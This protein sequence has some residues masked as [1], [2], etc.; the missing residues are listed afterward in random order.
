VEEKWREELE[1]L[2]GRP[3]TLDDLDRLPFTAMVFQE[4]LRLYPPALAFARRT[5]EEV[6][7]AGYTI[8]K[9]R[10]VFVSPYITQRNPKYFDSPEEFQPLRWKDYSG[11]KFAY[12][13]FGGGAKMCIGEPF[14]K[15]EGVIALATLGRRWKLWNANR[16]HIGVGPGFLLRPEAPI[17]LKAEAVARVN[18]VT[19]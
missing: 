16:G 6:T 18:A 15:L 5:R 13:P 11:P 4:G 12:F 17:M 19:Q 8:P 7:L 10:S 1:T 14:A 2:P 3:I 9:G